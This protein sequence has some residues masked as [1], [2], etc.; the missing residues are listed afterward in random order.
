MFSKKHFHFLY[1]MEKINFQKKILNSGRHLCNFVYFFTLFINLS[2]IYL[3][4]HVLKLDLAHIL[5]CLNYTEITFNY[6][7]FKFITRKKK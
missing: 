3:D 7:M 1:F 5:Y 4:S 6:K 2:G